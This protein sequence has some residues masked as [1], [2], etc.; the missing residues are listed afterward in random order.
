MKTLL[1]AIGWFFLLLV[2][3]PVVWLGSGFAYETWAT[4]VHRFRLTIEVETPDGIKSGAGVMQS[5]YMRKADWIPQTGGVIPSLRGDA[6][7]VDLGNGRNV[8]AIL[9]MGPTGSQDGITSLAARAFDRDKP[10]WFIDAPHWTGSAELDLDSVPTLVTFTD[11]NDP[12][13]A[14]SIYGT[15]YVFGGGSRRRV[16]L[17]EFAKTFG[18][19]FRFR[20]ATVEMVPIRSWPLRLLGLGGEPITRGIERR[21]PVIMSKLCDLDRGPMEVRLNRPVAPLPLNSGQLSVPAGACK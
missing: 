6:V 3:M 14:K 18:P 15:E 9:G 1:K 16:A 17:D 7:F 21:L 12:N 5:A 13:S 2:A 4:Y 20:R 19:G 10:L 8:I 11:L